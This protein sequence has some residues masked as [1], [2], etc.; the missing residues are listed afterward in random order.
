L[1]EKRL[2]ILLINKYRK[3]ATLLGIFA[4]VEIFTNVPNMPSSSINIKRATATCEILDSIKLGDN[5]RD[6][7]GRS[8]KVNKIEKMCIRIRSITISV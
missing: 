1:F 7:F 4:A 3:E 6:E 5:L 8:G 2:I